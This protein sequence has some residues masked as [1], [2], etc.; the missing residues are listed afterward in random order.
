MGT[1]AGQRKAVACRPRTFGAVP[2]RH[3]L[4]FGLALPHGGRP[5]GLGAL[6]RRLPGV[7]GAVHGALLLAEATL[8]GTLWGH[9]AE[10][11]L[12]HPPRP[13]APARPPT[14]PHSLATQRAGGQRRR[15][16]LMVAGGL[17]AGGHC[18]AG[19]VAR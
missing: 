3:A 15:L 10:P 1:L 18:A 17:A 7:A 12:C 9:R 19:R 11:R 14:S 4:T 8:H 5:Q 2:R 6:A 16:Q 13:G